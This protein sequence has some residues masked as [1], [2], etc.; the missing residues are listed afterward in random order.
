LQGLTLSIAAHSNVGIV[1]DTGGG[2]T[3]AVDLLPG[4]FAPDQCSI[5]VDGVALT[6][7]SIRSWQRSL[8]YVPQH[9][10]LTADSV[11][12]SI[13]FGVPA[14]ARGGAAIERAAR[15]AEL[16]DFVTKEMPQGYATI[17]GER[18][19][20]LSG[21]QRQRIGIA[22]ALYHDLDV[23]ILDEATSALDTL[24]ERAA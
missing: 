22:R 13:A 11:A 18:G 2:K 20:R 6:P 3:T 19:V 9:I 10:F 7:A 16:H 15:L 5:L 8:G 1:G 23:L 4:L 17:V 12:A 14:E 21:G 24:T